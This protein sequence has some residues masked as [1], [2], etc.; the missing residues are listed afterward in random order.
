MAEEV[1]LIFEAQ[2]QDLVTADKRLDKL[3][4]TGAKT[5]KVQKQM[6]V[7]QSKLASF[8]ARGNHQ[9]QNTAFQLQDI[10]VQLETGTS[11]SR[12]LGQQLPQLLGGF[13]ALGA[14]AGVVAGLG[15]ALGG[16]LLASMNDSAAA[17]KNLE[18]A[19]EELDQVVI[20]TDGGVIELTKEFQKL[21][22]VGGA[23]FSATLKEG[24]NDAK[25][26][27]KAARFEAIN[28][29][30]AISP[31]ELGGRFDTTKLRVEELRN[32]FIAGKIPLQQFALGLDE[33]SLK[34]S[35]L[36]KEF[37]DLRSG[38]RQQADASKDAFERLQELRA[39][40]QG[41]IAT[42]NEHQASVD[43]LISSLQIQSDAAND[44][45]N[46]T[47]F[48]RAQQLGA[49][50]AELARI[51][52]LQSVIDKQK[53]LVETQREAERLAE[54]EAEIENA[55][56]TA[57]QN[58]LAS[59]ED[60]LRSESA[61][62]SD[63]YNE[64]LAIINAGEKRGILEES[65]AS[66]LRKKNQDAF[67]KQRLTSLSGSFGQISSLMSSE[68]KKLFRIGQAAA[69]AQATIDGT[70]AIQKALSSLPP[71]G[72]FIVAA[73]VGASVGANVASIASAQPP[74]RAIGGQVTE[75]QA[76]RVGEYGPETFVPAS[77]GRIMPQDMAAANNGAPVEVVNNI[78]VLGGNENAQVTTQT[79][80]VSD[81]KIVQDIMVDMLSNQSSAPRQA[82][83]RTSNVVPRGNR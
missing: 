67:N 1:A 22:T 48:Y 7:G 38:V 61:A 25:D 82:L 3:N 46:S 74:G 2:T 69:I 13:G 66:D 57:F 45:G 32:Q 81:R 75:G 36:T 6:A 41:S 64:R 14:V 63:A 29:A 37:R 70:L 80:R 18:K 54:R 31:S 24:I 77:S 49:T 51:Q 78:K 16:V 9:I 28:L 44:A 21:A 79:T 40:E 55:R 11:V 73:L 68:N 15:F 20:R 17:S 10:V 56:T 30:E 26:A 43:R 42:V 23:A 33:I 27:I 76:Y 50:E 5:T 52:S 34:S 39:V 65:E 47:S 35:T 60:F 12:T 58:R 62:Y 8:F 4:K 71:P 83:Q 53:E 19:L 59:T 72:N